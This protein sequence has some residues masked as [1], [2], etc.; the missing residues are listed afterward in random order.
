MSF[1]SPIYFYC[2]TKIPKAKHIFLNNLHDFL[3]IS[4]GTYIF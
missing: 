1:F 4:I 3:K 2:K